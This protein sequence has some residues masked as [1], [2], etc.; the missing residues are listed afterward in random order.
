MKNLWKHIATTLIG[1]ITAGANV[2]LNGAETKTILTS[3]AIFILGAIAKDP[4]FLGGESNPP[5]DH[6]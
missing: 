2:Y 3:I 4:N 5:K 6:I 1:A